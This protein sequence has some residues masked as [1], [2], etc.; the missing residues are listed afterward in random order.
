MGNLNEDL[1]KFL[2]SDAVKSLVEAGILHISSEEDF[3]VDD[4]PGLEDIDLESMDL[5]SLQDLF[6]RLEDLMDTLE[7]EEPEDE[8][9]EEYELWESNT[10]LLEDF[11]D[12]VQ[13]RIDELEEDEGN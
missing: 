6:D 2:Q 4:I 13:D 1:E 9:S 8:D 3:T 12:T 7:S 5:H 10:A 11:M